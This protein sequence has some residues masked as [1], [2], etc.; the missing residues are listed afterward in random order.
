[1]EDI[2]NFKSELKRTMKL[3]VPLCK[4]NSWKYTGCG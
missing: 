1:V 3:Y 4:D 2:W